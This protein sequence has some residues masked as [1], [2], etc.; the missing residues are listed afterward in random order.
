MPEAP[1]IGDS[2]ETRAEIARAFRELR[3][4]LPEIAEQNALLDPVGAD[5]DLAPEAIEQF[6]NAYEALFLEALEGRG[7]ATRDLIFDTAL[8]PIMDR[9]RTALGMLRGNVVSAV[10]LTSQLLPLVREDLRREA[11]LWLAGFYADYTCE[12]AERAL[13][14]ETGRT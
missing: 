8:Q 3:P 2:D 1:S 4:R 7:H 6:I 5:Q 14:I 13:A 10:T 11:T 12:L 9:G